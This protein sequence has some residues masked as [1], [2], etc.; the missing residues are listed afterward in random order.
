MTAYRIVCQPNSELTS[1]LISLGFPLPLVIFMTW[2]TKKPSSFVFAVADS[3][4]K[5]LKNRELEK[6]DIAG[7]GIGVPG[8]V[9]KDGVV[10]NL[11][12]IGGWRNFPLKAKMQKRSKIPTA[13]DNDANVMGLAEAMFGAAKKI[14]NAVCITLGTGV[15]GAIIIDGRLYRGQNFF[16]G[17]L[18]HMPINKVG[19]RCRCGGLGCLEV[20]VGNNYLVKNFVKKIKLA[21]TKSL[22]TKLV[23]GD[24][25]KITPQILSDAARRKDRL[26]ILT[27][28]EAGENLGIA[29]SGVVNLLN[30][31][32]IIIGGGVSGAGAILFSSI[33]NTIKKRAIKLLVRDVKIVKA[34]LGSDA[35]VVGAAY[36][37]FM[38]AL[39]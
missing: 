35:G 13:I 9:N 8:F 17:E 33:K 29:L 38:E 1:L 5:I 31:A 11:T 34:R 19:P 36:L 16:A 22:V 28:R 24:L 3:I 14:K 7:I 32:A 2:P 20:Y 30:P 27:W 12:N 25:S 4:G 39:K 15:G 23:S 10:H 6:T 21:K 26:A 37:A 18:G